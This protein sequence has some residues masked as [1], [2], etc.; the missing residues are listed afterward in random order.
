MQDKGKYVTYKN[1]CAMQA[2][3][4]K[5]QEELRYED[6]MKAAG[7]APPAAG[8][9]TPANPFASAAAPAPAAANPFA[10]AAAPAAANPFATAA[11]PANPFASAAA[12]APAAANP[13]AAPAPAPAANPFAA[14][15]AAPANPFAAAPAPAAAN[16]FAAAPAPAAANPFAAAPA[17][18]AANPFAAA[19]APAAANPFAAAPAPAAA[20]PFAS[21]AAPAA[22]NPFASAA[23]PAAANPFA[24]ATA[25]TTASANPFATTTTTTAANPFATAAT[26]AAANPFAAATT[27]ATAANPFAAAT[28]T[29]NPFASVTAAPAAPTTTANPF[30]TAAA[31]PNPFATAAAPAAGVGFVVGG[32]TTAT[33]VFG[34]VGATAFLANGG[35]NPNQLGAVNTNL[36]MLP[37]QM[38]DPFGSMQLGQE[39]GAVVRSVPVGLR[40][41][42][43]YVDE[44]QSVGV[45]LLGDAG[46]RRSRV[47]MSSSGASASLPPRRRGY[48]PRSIVRVAPRRVQVYGRP[49][50]GRNR[51][52]SQSPYDADGR[53]SMRALQDAQ[54]SDLSS[55]GP[56]DAQDVGSGGGASNPYATSDEPLLLENGRPGNDA[57]SD[58]VGTP[59]KGARQGGGNGSG[60]GGGPDG[61]GSGGLDVGTPGGMGG[62]LARR[63]FNAPVAGGADD[64]EY[65]N[66]PAPVRVRNGV[67]VAVRLRDEQLQWVQL[68]AGATVKDLKSQVL[69]ERAADTSMG[70]MQDSG[71]DLG[72]DD[73]SYVLSVR[74]RLQLDSSALSEVQIGDLTEVQM[75][76][77]DNASR[78][79]SPPP[80]VDRSHARFQDDHDDGRHSQPSPR[81]GRAPV[82]TREGYRTEPPISE[83]RQRSSAELQAVRGFTVERE[84]IGSIEWLGTSD[85]EGLDLDSIVTID[86][87]SSAVYEG[88]E[89]PPKPGTKLNAAAMVRMY[90]VAPED[91][92]D[93]E[94]F[95]AMLREYTSEIPFATFVSWEPDTRVWTMHMSHFAAPASDSDVNDDGDDSDGMHHR[96]TLD[97]SIS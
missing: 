56:A 71:V 2:Y 19:P 84:G 50:Y 75:L 38:T 63:S 59:R 90:N 21:A 85:V 81:R 12:P 33:G 14:S 41:A 4:G 3:A 80:S 10:T 69:R 87:G 58:T 1:I 49:G 95:E 92:E 17:P 24:T 9:A 83:L 62:F 11:A 5:S 25:A 44:S 48:A 86:A 79:H 30:A 37:P 77:R 35:A 65:L 91:G 6:Y 36:G 89:R 51:L 82:L 70:G 31:A 28:T 52:E 94:E 26:T 40:E 22:A 32:A 72:V 34:G 18:A 97:M 7:G 54:H 23:A 93:N 66:S 74:G 45:G 68:P 46:L 20:N 73:E 57:G 15:A 43:A 61:G 8:A 88:I 27:T 76:E 53:M 60:S 78:M 55:L 16:P 13:F 29:A 42:E 67:R 96:S 47:T 64:E 39:V